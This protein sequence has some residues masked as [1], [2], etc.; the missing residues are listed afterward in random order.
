MAHKSARWINTYQCAGDSRG[1]FYK[2]SPPLRGGGQVSQLFAL[3]PVARHI[4]APTPA[5]IRDLYPCASVC[6]YIR[7]PIGVWG[8]K[9]DSVRFE[10]QSAAKAKAESEA[11]AK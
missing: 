8:S 10:K 6:I 9:A 4:D 3:G 11:K 7:R 1:R 2:D 5:E